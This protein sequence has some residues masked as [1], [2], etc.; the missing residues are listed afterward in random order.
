[1]IHLSQTCQVWR[2]EA[3]RSQMFGCGRALKRRNFNPFRIRGWGRRA[4]PPN[5]IGANS[6]NSFGTRPGMENF[7]TCPSQ[8][9]PT[10]S[11]PERKDGSTCLNS[12]S[13]SQ[14][15]DLRDRGP[16]FDA[17]RP[18][19]CGLSQLLGFLATR[20]KPQTRQRRFNRTIWHILRKPNHPSHFETTYTKHLL[21]PVISDA[22][23]R[24]STR[25]HLRLQHPFRL[26]RKTDLQELP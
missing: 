18:A 25:C 8:P 24:R 6:L 11:V 22:A 7:P 2:N 21:L 26:I 12:A 13:L 5:L 19:G 1:M 20:I 14:I 3:Q 4:C 17:L 23:M 16:L 9:S 15:L 10:K